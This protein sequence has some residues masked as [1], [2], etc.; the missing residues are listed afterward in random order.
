[1]GAEKRPRHYVR[2]L[3]MIGAVLR[4]A[5][6]LWAR[7]DHQVSH[8]RLLSSRALSSKVP[9]H[10]ANKGLATLDLQ[11]HTRAI[12]APSVA[13]IGDEIAHHS[14]PAFP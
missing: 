13:S 6:L 3:R 7:Q 10:E 1:M 12:T 4:R 11:A 9:L 8:C 2:Q 5:F 14:A